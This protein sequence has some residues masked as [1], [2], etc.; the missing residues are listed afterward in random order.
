MRLMA[1]TTWL[2]LL[3]FAVTAAGLS[4][5]GTTEKLEKTTIRF[6]HTAPTSQATHLAAVR[7]AER[8]AEK[9]DGAVNIMIF[10]ASQLGSEGE[11]ME[12]VVLNEIQMSYTDPS[13][14]GKDFG[15]GKRTNGKAYRG[16]SHNE[17]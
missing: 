8:V 2:V 9:T 13:Y 14:I 6:A 12:Q 11:I 10:P 7:M 17:R 15:A 16:L 1:K 3:V 4:A 5:E